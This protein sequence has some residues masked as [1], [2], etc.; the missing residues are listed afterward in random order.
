[1]IAAGIDGTK[2]GWIVVIHD[3]RGLKIFGEPSLQVA[4]ERLS[5]CTFVAIDMP[6]GFLAGA[7]PGG[8]ACE[9]LARAAMPGRASSVFSSPS[10]P[11]LSHDDY[12]GA[13]EANRASS[14]FGLGLSKQSHALFAKMRELDGLMTPSLQNRV[15]E[16]HPEVCFT[17]LARLG[18]ETITAGKKTLAGTLQRTRLLEAAGFEVAALRD[19]CRR[20]GAAED[21]VHD[22]AVACWT[23]LRRARGDAFRLPIQPPL[24]EHG[25]LMEMW[26]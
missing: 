3:G 4:L 19:D 26:V 14:K 21:D 5:E 12:A 23:A 1:M 6:I 15:F 7:S 13:S 24:D 22:A 17:E 8:R 20:H 25:L 10:R 11:A 16:V 9:A 18:G 2:R